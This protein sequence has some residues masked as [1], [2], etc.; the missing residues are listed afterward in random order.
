[1]TPHVACIICDL[2]NCAMNPSD[3]T[4]GGYFNSYMHN[5][6]LT[7]GIISALSS[8]GITTTNHLL[9]HRKLLT[10]SINNSGSNR[11][12]YFSGCSNKWEWKDNQ[13]ISLLS[14]IQ[15]YGSI[16]YSSSGF[17]TGEACEK[18]AL[19]NF[20]RPNKLFGK[21][22]IWLRDV[23]SV[24]TFAYLFECGVA[25]HVGAGDTTIAPVPLILLK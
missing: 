24:N 16:I 13:F 3:T 5:N 8:V 18:L 21:K 2:P 12:G 17:D 11:T 19:F 7:E 1:M 14:E 22:N 15:L 23:S 10:K 25:G 9:S 20:I 6:F 4:S